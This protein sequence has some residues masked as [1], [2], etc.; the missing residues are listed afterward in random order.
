MSS[1]IFLTRLLLAEGL[2]IAPFC[3]YAPTAAHTLS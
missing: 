1:A 2:S 3:R